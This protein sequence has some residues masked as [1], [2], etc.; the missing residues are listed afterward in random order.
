MTGHSGMVLR[1]MALV[2]PGHMPLV[3]VNQQG[4]VAAGTT[5]RRLGRTAADMMTARYWLLHPAA[6]AVETLTK[7]MPVG[8]TVMDCKGRGE[9][10]GEKHLL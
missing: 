10:G 1:R 8:G 5:G 9:G 6:I 7:V 2:I 4:Q 3:G